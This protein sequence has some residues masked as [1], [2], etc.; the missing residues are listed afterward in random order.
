MAKKRKFLDFLDMIDGGGAGKMG[1]EF[2]GGGLLSAFANMAASPYGSED[3]TRRKAR[4]DFYS[5]QNIG[6]G[7]QVDSARVSR[8]VARPAS[9][10]SGMSPLERFGGMPPAPYEAPSP[11]ER[12]GGMPPAPYTASSPL[13]QFGG[14]QPAPYTA[15]TPTSFADMEGQ[16]SSAPKGFRYLTQ[17]EIMDIEGLE[18]EKYMQEQALRKGL[19]SGFKYYPDGNIISIKPNTPIPH[20]GM[21][22]A[23][24]TALAEKFVPA[25]GN[26]AYNA[27]MFVPA[28]GNLAYNAEKF[29]PPTGERSYTEFLNLLG[30]DVVRTNSPENLVAAYQEYRN[31]F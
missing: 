16:Y 6:G 25:D 19:I 27:E 2:E 28:D 31:S 24:Y 23:P 14:M 12:F 20:V 11:L 22:P 10:T 5:S 15:P 7:P 26:L 21:Q 9:M 30:P 29:A 4:Q 3:E 18:N 13:E 8:P 1:D 17:D